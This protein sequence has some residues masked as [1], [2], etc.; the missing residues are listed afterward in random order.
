MIRLPPGFPVRKKDG[1]FACVG[2]HLPHGADNPKMWT[3]EEGKF[4]VACHSF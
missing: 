2:C 3:V 1:V 4:C